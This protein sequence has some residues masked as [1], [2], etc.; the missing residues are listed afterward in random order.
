MVYPLEII[1]SK[2]ACGDTEED[3]SK[4]TPTR[5]A[6]RILS[7]AGPLGFFKGVQYS[8]SKSGAEK[9]IYFYAYSFLRKL[10]ETYIGKIGMAGNIAVGYI[11][12]WSHL[13]VTQPMET[14]L[15][16][17]QNKRPMLDERG[18]AG[19]FKGVSAQVILCFKNAIQNTVF[20]Q[21]K[22]VLLRMNSRGG[23]NKAVTLSALQAFLL[24]ALAR[25]VA[26]IIVWPYQRSKV[27]MQTTS[28]KSKDGASQSVSG[29]MLK[30]AKED[31]V[32]ALYQG[33]PPE[34]MRGVGSASIMYLLK[35]KIF[36]LTK[37]LIMAKK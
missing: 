36:E 8:S 5:I 4:L 14:I 22:A 27:V 2:L 23:A 37:K 13:P 25:A 20:D 15:I 17:V 18:V 6:R 34:L 33:L 28:G 10:Y 31:G 26:T 12:D 1:K 24:G 3:G 9:F 21:I 32:L 7:E 29:V 19:L 16:R 35:E 11:A 30:I